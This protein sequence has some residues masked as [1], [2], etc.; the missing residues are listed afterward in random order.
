[1]LAFF[2]KENGFDLVL[3]WKGLDEK[4][5]EKSLPKWIRGVGLT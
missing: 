2:L 1:M 3:S 5:A 4:V